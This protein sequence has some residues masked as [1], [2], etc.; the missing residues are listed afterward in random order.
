MKYPLSDDFSEILFRFS[1][2]KKYYLDTNFARFYRQNA[3]IE[4]K[5]RTFI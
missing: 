5:N 1:K 4:K 3:H 2:R